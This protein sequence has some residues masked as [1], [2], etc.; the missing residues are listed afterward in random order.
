MIAI[1]F[2]GENRGEIAARLS[3]LPTENTHKYSHKFDNR[4]DR[5]VHN[6]RPTDNEHPKTT[7]SDKLAGTS[8]ARMEQNCQLVAWRIEI[9][10]HRQKFTV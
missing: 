1:L 10:R 8:R 4:L 5:N 3:E 7:P 2:D 9:I 6:Q